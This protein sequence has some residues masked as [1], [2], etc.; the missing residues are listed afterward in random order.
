MPTFAER[1]YALVRQV[2]KGSVITYGA[3][4]RVLGEPG[5]A[6]QVGW[7]MAACPEDARV[8]AHRVIN[9][10]GEVSG[11]QTMR[12]RKQLKADGVVFL[13]DG[14]VD[15][16]RCLWLPNAAGSGCGATPRE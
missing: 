11:G 4:A 13:Q 7:A 12:R 8:P 10:R 3:I 14:R 5:K 6:R 9:A 1:V 15:L 16:D 2:P